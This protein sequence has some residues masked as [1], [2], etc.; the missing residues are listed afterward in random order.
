MPLA[1]CRFAHASNV[2]LD[3]TL[4]GIGRVSDDD[5]ETLRD[6]T[7]SAFERLITTCLE[8]EVAFLLLA[9][10]TFDS[11]DT[12]TRGRAAFRDGMECLA[13]A[14][15][16]TVVVPGKHDPAGFW[17][18]FER[19]PDSVVVVDPFE[20]RPLRVP[21]DGRTLATI[22]TARTI[23]VDRGRPDDRDGELRPPRIL[24]G[25]PP[26]ERT[27]GMEYVALVGDVRRSTTAG[28]PCIH[29]AGAL[30]PT[31]AKA[32]HGG[33]GIVEVHGRDGTHVEHVPAAVVR[34]DR[35][36]HDAGH[37]TASAQSMAETL[38]ERLSDVDD[39]VAEIRIVT[40][41]VEG[42]PRNLRPKY[43]EIASR[44]DDLW[45]TFGRGRVLH[46]W[47][48][49]PAGT[50]DDDT[51]SRAVRE[52]IRNEPIDAEAVLSGVG[53]PEL[54]GRLGHDLDRELV[55]A[56]AETCVLTWLQDDEQG[57][58]LP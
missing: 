13:E 34:W 24:V 47:E 27:S 30:Q 1:G 33:F 42:D 25:E 44:F 45:P 51:F 21:G 57:G 23:S 17:S 37:G 39:E 31:S 3:A 58:R 38:V 32:G 43:R 28:P 41:V 56:R 22:H 10:G 36:T 14:G 7:L 19:L 16:P 52:R 9:G 26:L 2:R 49:R 54:Y 20:D 35:I 6:A 40:W 15:V 46:R 53:S 12:S 5:C 11:R 29:H 50:V 8:R 4:K 55:A 48:D 18:R